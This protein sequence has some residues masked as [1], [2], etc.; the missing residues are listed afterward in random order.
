M[1]AL[2]TRGSI[3][4]A[5]VLW[6]RSEIAEPELAI[7]LRK[8]GA[9]VVDPPAYN[10]VPAVPAALPQ[11]LLG[12]DAGQIGATAFL[13][14]SSARGLA[15]ALDG[16]LQTLRGRTLVA[17]VGPTTSQAIMALGASV[18]IEALERRGDALAAAIADRLS[19]RQGDAA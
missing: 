14:P 1:A 3:N 2:V 13:S 19:A 8:H 16:T 15:A 18:D 10:T 4:G 5:H 17:S 6:P 11:F 9:V 7:A 12:L